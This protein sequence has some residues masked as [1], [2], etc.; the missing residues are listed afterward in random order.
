MSILP[1]QEIYRRIQAGELLNNANADLCLGPASYELRIGSVKSFADAHDQKLEAGQ[2][3]VMEPGA[4]A[5]I[6][7]LE[8]VRMPPDLCGFLFL[9]SSLG[10]SGYIPWSQ[11]FV[12]PG[13]KGSLTIS[14][15]NAAGKLQ[16]FEGHAK[17]CH[18]AFMKLTA[19]TTNPYESEYQGSKGATGSKQKPPIVISSSG[20]LL[21]KI[22]GAVGDEAVR[23]VVDE[24]VKA[25]IERS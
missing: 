10:R 18:L 22:F 11:G 25:L 6:G 17:I 3:F 14:L 8:E 24:G 13:Y 9:K 23:A 12:D 19:E 21:G 5:L 16:L 1:Y 15:H 20:Q 4:S 7:T 2:K